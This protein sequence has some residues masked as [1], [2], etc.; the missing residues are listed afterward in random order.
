VVREI[1]AL[2]DMDGTILADRH[3]HGPYGLA[4]G[5][6]GTPGLITITGADGVAHDLPAKSS[7]HLRAGDVIRIHTPGGG[8]F[9]KP[10]P[11]VNPPSAS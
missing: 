8:G 11:P 6:S 10:Q 5:G 4:G 1:E 2:A 3:R 7:L 9:G